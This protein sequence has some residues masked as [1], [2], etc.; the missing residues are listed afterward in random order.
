MEENQTNNV[1]V[2]KLRTNRGL[3]KF[4]LLTIVTLG[5]YA[6]VCFSHVSS[7]INKVAGPYD[8]RKTLHFCLVFF[9]LTPITAGIFNLIW[10]SMLCSRMDDELTRRNIEYKFGAGTYWGW[11]FFG[12]LIL[13]GPFIFLYKF[14]KAMNLLN[15][16]YNVKG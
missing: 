8:H 2:M 16:D 10:W 14:F 6:I 4:I 5:I 7:E 12:S 15:A 1:P 9:I 11:S 13:V 3:L